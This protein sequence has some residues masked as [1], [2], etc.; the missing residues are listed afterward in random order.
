MLALERA[1]SVAETSATHSRIELSIIMPCLNEAETIVACIAKARSFIDRTGVIGEI[2]VADNGST[3]G[4]QALARACGARVIDVPERGYGAA[5]YGAMSVARG[6]YI[7]MGDSDCSYDFGALD[8]F[9]TRLREGHD[10]VMGDRFSGG[11]AP[12]AMPWKNRWIGNPVLSMIGRR[13]FKTNVR[14]FHCGLRGLSREAFNRMDLRTSGMEYA[15]E[16]IIKATLG[17]MRISEVPTTLSVDGR[18]RRPHLRPYRDGWRHLR[19]MLLFNQ[20]WLFLYPGLALLLSGLLGFLALQAGP[21]QLGDVRLSVDTLVYCASMIAVGM[22]AILFSIVSR[23]FA[24]Q[25][26]LYPA[27]KRG[28]LLRWITMERG[29]GLGVCVFLFG[30][31]GGLHAL[32]L[33]RNAEFGALEFETVLRITITSA[34]GLSVGSQIIF[35][36][37]LLGTIRLNAARMRASAEPV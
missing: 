15:S 18:L 29:L 14:D 1:I 21:V 28:R 13:F 12:G 30:M 37:F 7:I 19:F 25:E 8:T 20:S 3:D 17:G 26:R 6:T 10:L 23:E 27:S 5:L 35:S 2:L 31:T 24:V 11:I 36:S 34:L 4:S 16:M 22:Q 32:N 33:W 9:L